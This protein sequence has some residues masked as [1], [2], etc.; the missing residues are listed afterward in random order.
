MTA[1]AKSLHRR[2]AWQSKSS[3]LFLASVL[4]TF[5]A[6]DLPC[7]V[8]KKEVK[9]MVRC[10]DCDGPMKGCQTR[11]CQPCFRSYHSYAN[12][13]HMPEVYVD[14]TW[15]Y[16]TLTD[17]WLQLRASTVADVYRTLPD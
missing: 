6:Y 8:C 14:N 11:F 9:D 13:H 1:Q 5:A 15:R 12:Q 4:H 10:R 3:E 16:V 7:V 2:R 17:N